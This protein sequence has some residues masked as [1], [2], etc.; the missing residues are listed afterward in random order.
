MRI[1]RRLLL[2]V[3]LTFAAALSAQQ[4][5]PVAHIQGPPP[6][7]GQRS[8]LPPNS[9]DAV[10]VSGGVMAGQIIK[11][12][13]PDYPAS[14]DAEGAVVLHAIID[15]DGKVMQLSVISGPE[16][17]APLA[18]NAVRQWEYKPY[19]LNGEPVRVDT[20][21]VVNFRR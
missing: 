3:T 20:T 5:G 17:L 7:P 15:T 16:P 19:L 12:V 11:R 21:I 14:L 9:V 18:V 1:R 4:S 13:P 6:P 8:N 2:T 10:R